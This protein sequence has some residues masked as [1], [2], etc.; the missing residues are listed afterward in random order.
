MKT[1]FRIKPYSH[2]HLKW[3]VR[4]KIA[5]TWARKYFKTKPEAETYRDLKNGELSNQGVEAIEF[6]TELRVM[7][8]RC[9]E[10]LKSHG[11]TIEDAT[12][13]YLDRLSKAQKAIP[14][15][16]AIKELIE[17]R[18]ATGSSKV[19]CYDLSLRLG[20]FE[21]SF[22][23]RVTEDFS[24]NE[25][26]RW[27]LKLDV[28]AVTRNTYRRDLLTMFSFCVQRGYSSMNPVSNTRPSKEVQKPVGILTVAEIVRLLGIAPPTIVPYFA[29]GA[30][31]GLRTAEIERLNW[32]E[33]DTDLKHIEVTADKAKTAQRRIVDIQ[34]NLK[35]W[36]Q[37]HQKA[38]GSIVPV[39]LRTLY[40]DARIK[41][42]LQKWPPNALR[43]SYASYH[44][45]H[46]HDAAALALQMGHTG[47]NLIFR[48]YREVVKPKDAVEYWKVTPDYHGDEPHETEV[49]ET[50]IKKKR[51][52]GI[53]AALNTGKQQPGNGQQGQG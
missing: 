39:N 43:H 2:P 31:A 20:R 14:L 50:T 24:T 3:V 52:K 35:T 19:Y 22:T 16:Q 26:E 12:T 1:H 17:N 45:A 27:L 29:I 38:T 13:F 5:G 23:D 42:G 6:S 40:R 4:G 34:P 33:V 9:S 10:R 18:K 32:S 28:E 48:H 37:L 49:T 44:L 53:A 30:F 15:K 47:T 41:A 7:A 11:K 8:Q 51:A 46:F 36:L 25:I 21:K